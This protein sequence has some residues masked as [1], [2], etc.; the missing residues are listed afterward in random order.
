CGYKNAPIPPENVVPAA[1]SDL[2]YTLGLKGVQ[3]DWLYPVETIGGKSLDDI[4]SFELYWA[5][6]PIEDYCAACPIPFGEPMEIGGGP[7]FDGKIRRKASYEFSLLRAGYKYFFKVRS[8]TSWWADSADSN[9]ITFVWFQPAAAPEGVTATAGDRQ[10]VL[11]WQP[12]TLLVDGSPVEG[13]MKYQVLRSIGGKDFE[14]LGEPVAATDYVDRQ[15]SNGLEYFYIIRSMMVLKDDLVSGRV[16][17]AVAATPLDLNPPPT[18]MGVTVV[19]TSVGIKIFWD[20][21]AATDL[22]GYRVYRRA[23]GKDSYELLGD[24]E[25]IYTLFVDSKA[26]D[27]VQYYYAVT[28]FDQATPPNES[29]KSTEATARY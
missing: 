22:G 3:L 10:V 5:E 9:I 8:R 16:S 13:V 14:R 29:K 15:V 4:S 11:K 6:I 1:I 21:S 18:P 20:K 23:A 2:K 12:V 25:S 19:R 7:P 27:S 17:K 28:A 24:V 26:G